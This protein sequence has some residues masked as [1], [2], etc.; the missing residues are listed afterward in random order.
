MTSDGD[1]VSGFVP[2]SEKTT[3]TACANNG[4]ITGRT[5]VGGIGADVK[6]TRATDCGNTGAISLVKYGTGNQEIGGLFARICYAPPS[7]AAITPAPSPAMPTSA[8]LSAP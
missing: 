2:K 1:Y 8:A 7:P 4:A 3:Y 6:S 5:K